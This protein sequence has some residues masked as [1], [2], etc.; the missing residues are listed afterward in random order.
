[1]RAT[2]FI[3]ENDDQA[4]VDALL[5]KHGWSIGKTVNGD[6]AI[7]W[8][9]ST[10]VFYGERMRITLP[11]GKSVS[12]VWGQK[13]DW[14]T[15]PGELSF[16]QAVQQKYLTFDLPIWQ[17][18]DRGQINDTQA[19][20]RFKIE[21]ERQ[22]REA[23]AQGV[24]ESIVE[25]ENPKVDLTP[26]YPN[27]QVLVGEFVG[28]KKNRLLFRILS[29]ELKP[30]Q[31]ETEKI[32]RALTTNTPIGIEV[33][34]VKNRTVIEDLSR[35][36]FLGG[37][38]GMAALGTRDTKPNS[39]K[40]TPVQK[41]PQ[42]EPTITTLSNNPQIESLL[43]KAAV[44]A[45][46]VGTELAQ[47][48]AQTKHESW[49]FSRLKEKG[50]GQGYFAKKYDRQYAPRTAKILGNKHVGD[51]EKYHGRGFIQLTGRDNYRMA[52]QALG[53]DLLNHP[54]LAERPD[55]AAKIAIWYWQTRVKPYINNF[56]DTKAV[57]Q[58]INPALRGLQDRHAKFIDYKNI[59]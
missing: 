41:E 35:R 21:N 31:G 44:A 45:G 11:D 24:T 13:P 14:Q 57:T 32:F 16:A 1:V 37:L 42:K 23:I 26:N 6:L 59:L 58:K 56:N 43:H 36:G 33:G 20:Q 17:Q 27:Y 29:A 53:I 7:T 39:N 12:V 50:V 8:Q 30:G 28:V 46:I 15:R 22:A 5:K 49:D 18:L 52:S 19:L 55:V 54:E 38:A 40:D 25:Q 4:A 47:F 51:G 34:K 10:Y 9:G 2:D 48:M 3:I